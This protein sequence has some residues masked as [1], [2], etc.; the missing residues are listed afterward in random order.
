MKLTLEPTG[1]IETV[2]GTPCRLWTGADENGTPVHAYVATMQPQTHDPER[3]AAFAAALEEVP[4]VRQ[5]VYFDI[6][7]AT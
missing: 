4:L 1:I 2:E 6:R 3:L 7:M 5:L